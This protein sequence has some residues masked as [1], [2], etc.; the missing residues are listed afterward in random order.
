VSY[1]I[2]DA[3][4]YG[5]EMEIVQPWGRGWSTFL[6][7]TFQRSR[8][9]GDMFLELFVDPR[10]AGFDEIPGLPAHRV[11][12]GVRYRMRNNA[13]LGLFAQVCSEQ[14]VIYNDNTL[15]NTQMRSLAVRLRPPDWSWYPVSP[16]L[17]S[18]LR[19]VF[20]LD[21]RELISWPAGPSGLSEDRV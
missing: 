14:K 15:Y 3:R 5:I 6:N 21:C 11:N 1:N 20:V 17:K 19:P 18:C 10:D 13:S 4:L 12:L 2:G 16:L 9:E 8:T 7:Y